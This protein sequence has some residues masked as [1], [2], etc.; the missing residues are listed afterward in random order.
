MAEA[1]ELYGQKST[2]DLAPC[3]NSLHLSFLPTGRLAKRLR[4]D[5]EPQYEALCHLAVARCEQSVGNAPAEAEALVAASRSFLLAEQK[6][7]HVGCPSFEEHL[8]AGEEEQLCAREKC[9]A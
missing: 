1:G 2:P 3:F 9:C 8:M 5:E 6:I 4:S 7:Q